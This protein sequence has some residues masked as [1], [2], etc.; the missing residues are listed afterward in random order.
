MQGCSSIHIGALLTHYFCNS[1]QNRGRWVLLLIFPWT[2]WVLAC[3]F[4]VLWWRFYPD[5]NT[6]EIFQYSAKNNGA[7]HSSPKNVAFQEKTG[8][9][10]TLVKLWSCV[11]SGVRRRGQKFLKVSASSV[12]LLL[13][14]QHRSNRIF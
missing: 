4:S 5:A 3:S 14:F 7:D 6:Q 12:S 1:E 13:S 9:F 10:L 2:E 8:L 11:T